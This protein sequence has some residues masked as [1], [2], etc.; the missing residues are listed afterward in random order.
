MKYLDGFKSENVHFTW[1]SKNEPVLAVDDGEEL[2]VRVPDASTSQ[3]RE[4]WTT[5]D[6][7]K[8]DES[9]LDGAVGPIYVRGAK[10]G[11]ALEVDV[12]EVRPGRWGWTAI[13][14][15]FGV[16]DGLFAERLVI[17]D[18]GEGYATTRGDF[19]RGVRVP[20]NPFL[21]VI[22]VAPEAGEYDVIPPQRFGGNMDN[23][24]LTAG[25]RLL[26]PV[27]VDGALLSVGDP[28]ASQGDG[29]VCGTAIETSAEVR[30]RV[31][32]RDGLKLSY[33]VAYVPAPRS[34]RG[35]MLVAMGISGDLREAMSTSVRNLIDMVAAHGFS[36]DEAYVLM[37][38]CGELRVSEAVDMP[39]FTVSSAVPLEVLNR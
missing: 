22:G 31:K 25:T 17:W 27:E 34:T 37:S 33:P 6:L 2:A 1:S 36:R 18:I 11:S 38:V 19:L 20:L 9:R 4:G 26:L 21:G 7:E 28:H 15:G 10:R 8:I 32:V 23:R 24:L 39:N 35:E 12:E 30:M 29:E 14:K 13:M 16:L 5:E 3:I